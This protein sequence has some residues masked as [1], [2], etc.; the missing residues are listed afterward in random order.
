MLETYYFSKII[1]CGL[2]NGSMRGV[3]ERGVKKYICSNNSK[4]PNNCTRNKIEEQLLIDHVLKYTNLKNIR[5]ELNREYFRSLIEEVRIYENQ[6]FV[7]RY[8]DGSE[9]CMK[10]NCI[11][12]V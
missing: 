7:I 1:L 12:Y 9:G 4:N 3:S 6:D 11:R 10:N 5:Y 2:C 8:K